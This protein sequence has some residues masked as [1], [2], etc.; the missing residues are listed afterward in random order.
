MLSGPTLTEGRSSRS[1]PRI[2]WDR[3]DIDGGFPRN[4]NLPLSRRK[5]PRRSGIWLIRLNRSKS[6]GL[7]PRA[8]HFPMITKF[9]PQI[10]AFDADLETRFLGTDLI[11]ISEAAWQSKLPVIMAAAAAS[12]EVRSKAL[13]AW[14]AQQI[15]TMNQDPGS[16]WDAFVK[17]SS[18]E[19]VASIK[20]GEVSLSDVNEMVWGAY[21][22]SES[23]RRASV[24]AI[25]NSFW[26]MIRE[27]LSDKMD[28]HVGKVIPRHIVRLGD[29]SAPTFWKY[30]RNAIIFARSKGLPFVILGIEEGKSRDPVAR[31]KLGNGF[32]CG[33]ISSTD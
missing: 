2:D 18:S 19:M 8:F 25:K 28:K 26:Q 4:W 6:C 16:P 5:D 10:T 27:S 13:A 1:L 32:T 15:G 31:G 22:E 30:R 33:A 3:N 7:T 23:S 14:R 11:Q 29:G 9:A 20:K 24:K 17:R 12:I 21:E